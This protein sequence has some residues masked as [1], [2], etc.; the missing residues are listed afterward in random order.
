MPDFVKTYE[1]NKDKLTIVGIDMNDS[2]Q[3][4]KDFIGQHN[5][6]YPIVIDDTGDLIY[7]YRVTGHPTSIFINKDGVITGIV[8]GMA[9]P[10]VLEKEVAKALK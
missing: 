2:L 4:V 5:V 6:T 3:E 1:A 7:K 9:T 10:D 8:P